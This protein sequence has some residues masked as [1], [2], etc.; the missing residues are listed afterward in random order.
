M[1]S[2]I[3]NFRSVRHFENRAGKEP[4]FEFVFSRH[5]DA[6]A[7]STEY[8][9]EISCTIVWLGHLE[10]SYEMSAGGMFGEWTTDIW[11]KTNGI[12]CPLELENGLDLIVYSKRKLKY[13]YWLNIKEI[14]VWKLL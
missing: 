3:F 8:T 4:A 10:M 6:S 12:F 5:F 2:H 7:H 1:F 13:I 14:V 9:N 11:L